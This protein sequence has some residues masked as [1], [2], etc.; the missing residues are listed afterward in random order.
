MFSGASGASKGSR[1]PTLLPSRSPQVLTETAP[2]TPMDADLV[3]DATSATY[4]DVYRTAQPS[5]AWLWDRV[6]DLLSK[7]YVNSFQLMT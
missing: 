2:P 1:R 7:V 3:A 4:I 5:V 6:P